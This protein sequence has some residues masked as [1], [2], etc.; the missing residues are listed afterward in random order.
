M[1]LFDRADRLLRDALEVTAHAR[2]VRADGIRPGDEFTATFTVENVGLGELAGTHSRA[3]F[4]DV[5]LRIEATPFAS[6]LQDGLQV[7]AVTKTFEQLIYG[8]AATHEITMLATAA[9]DGPEPFAR[10]HA[11]GMLDLRRFFNAGTV[12]Q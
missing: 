1:S 11:H 4:N 8:E 12:H 5:T 2:G 10:V 9:L 3:V 7:A 6:P